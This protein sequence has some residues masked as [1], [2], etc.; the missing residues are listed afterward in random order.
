MKNFRKIAL[1]VLLSAQVLTT[2][3]SC[4]SDS[5]VNQESESLSVA[6]GNFEET[7]RER[8]IFSYNK[9][10]RI[11]SDDQLKKIGEDHN[12]FLKGILMKNDQDKILTLEELKENVIRKYPLLS[13]YKESTDLVIDNSHSLTIDDFNLLIDKNSN[14][15]NNAWALKSFVSE[16]IIL[17][18]EYTDYDSF[19]SSLNLIKNKA[20]RDLIGVDLDAYLV[21]VSVFENSVKFWFEENNYVSYSISS[22]PSRSDVARADGLSASI[23]FL[24]LAAVTSGVAI[25]AGSG[26]LATPAIVVVME[27][28]GVGFG[29]ALSSAAVIIGVG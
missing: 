11:F 28:L 9:E 27:L 10:L 24:T 25:A 16:T 7:I 14:L 17:T 20:K 26:G 1:G 19:V 3:Y 29:A 22:K 4:S 13:S 8:K 21:F 6:N 5:S 18:E 2:F 12:I 23:G 15:V